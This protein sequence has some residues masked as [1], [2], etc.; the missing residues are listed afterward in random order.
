MRRARSEDQKPWRDS[1]TKDIQVR[2]EEG[3]A[4]EIRFGLW[5]KPTGS[6]QEFP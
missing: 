2:D 6:H 1:G 5:I 3:E 4:I